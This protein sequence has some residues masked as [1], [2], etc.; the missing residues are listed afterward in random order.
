MT[1][2]RQVWTRCAGTRQEHTHSARWRAYPCAPRPARQKREKENHSSSSQAPISSAT[3]PRLFRD[4]SATLPPLLRHSSATPPRLFFCMLRLLL[5]PPHAHSPDDVSLCLCHFS[6]RRLSVSLSHVSLCLCH[7]SGGAAGRGLASTR[8]AAHARH[9]LARALAVDERGLRLRLE[10]GALTG[11]AGGW[12]CAQ[13]RRRARERRALRLAAGGLAPCEQRRRGS[14]RG[15]P[16]GGGSLGGSLGGGALGRLRWQLDRISARRSPRGDCAA[17]DGGRSEPAV[18]ADAPRR[19]SR[20]RR[21]VWVAV[22]SRRRA[23]DRITSGHFEHERHTTPPLCIRPLT[24]SL[25][26]RPPERPRRAQRRQK[27]KQKK[28]REPTRP[29][30]P[31]CHTPYVDTPYA[32]PHMSTPHMSTP[33]PFPYMI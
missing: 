31:M 6:R 13:A 5:P 4:S 22:R 9:A 18:G 29:I 26:R 11:V 14:W 10:R 19:R 7:Y 17:L 3:L 8:G 16:L 28:P 2:L 12:G 20:R 24:A 25:T 21:P 23:S 33:H 27:K 1:S 15:C 32:T 30:W